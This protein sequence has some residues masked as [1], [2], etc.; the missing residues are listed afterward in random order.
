VKSATFV[1]QRILAVSGP[2]L[3]AYLASPE[4]AFI[5]GARLRIDGLAV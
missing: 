5:R 1:A 4:A 3:V 2:D